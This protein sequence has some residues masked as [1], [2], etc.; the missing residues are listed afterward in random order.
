M[1]A[2]NSIRHREFEEKG[3][4]KKGKVP[5]S[6]KFGRAWGAKGRGEGRGGGGVVEP[7]SE[8][9]SEEVTFQI[10]LTGATKWLPSPWLCIL[11][12]VQHMSYDSNYQ[13]YLA[14]ILQLQPDL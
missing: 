9:A 11:A 4:S 1:C 12:V 5:D 14:L 2:A 8:P 3:G 10:C 13:V 7:H 6:A